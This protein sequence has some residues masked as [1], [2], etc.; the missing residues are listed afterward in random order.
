[1]SLES[2]KAIARRHFE[3]LWDRG[4]LD[5]ADEIYSPDAV[6]HLRNEPDQGGYPA[7]EK[8]L[9]GADRVAFPDGTVS[10]DDQIAEGDRVV[11]RWRFRGT[12]TGP[13]LGNPPTGREV[14][15]SGT[16]IHRIA[17]GTIAEIWAQPDALTFMQQLGLL[18]TP[19]AQTV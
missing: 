13:F 11:T 17:D 6:G 4:H 7:C 9:V 2:N 1:M 14:S 16:H 3:E 5:V 12:N 15:V 18:P 10:V 19:T 8:E